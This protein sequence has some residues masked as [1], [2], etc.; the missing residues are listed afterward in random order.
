MSFENDYGYVE[1][2][3]SVAVNTT[4]TVYPWLKNLRRFPRGTRN[5][6][7]LQLPDEAS[8]GGAYLISAS[9]LYGNYDNLGVPPTL[10]LYVGVH[11]WTTVEFRGDLDSFSAVVFEDVIH[12]PIT[13]TLHVCLVKI[14]DTSGTPFISYLQV[15][16]LTAGSIYRE[17]SGTDVILRLITRLDYASDGNSTEIVV[18]R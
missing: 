8:G 4:T 12:V 1:S 14:N 2:G 10:D 17:P 18:T 11:Y 13:D 5:C 3:E 7:T 6:Y 15:R 9:F 16:S